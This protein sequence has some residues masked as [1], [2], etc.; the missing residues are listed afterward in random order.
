M[1]EDTL[2][3]SEIDLN[4]DGKQ[5]GYL[6]VPHSVHRSAY[7]WLPVPIVSIKNGH[8]PT[9]L[10]MGGNHGDEYEGQ[11]ALSNLSRSL[12]AKDIK[13]QLIILPAANT[14][15]AQAGLRT[16]PIDEGNLNR[17]F[18]GIANG[19]PTQMIAHYIESVLL[20]HADY[21][22]DIHSGGSS[23]LYQPTL[24]A[25][26]ATNQTLRTKQMALI[27]SLGFPKALIYPEQ[28]DGTYSS[29]AAGRQGVIA[30]T[31][32]IA[33]AGSVDAPALSFLETVLSR[34]LYHIDITPQLTAPA[35]KAA[36]ALL[37]S[38]SEEYC[39]YARDDGVFEP[40]ADIGHEISKDQ[41]VGRIHKPTQPWQPPLDITSPVQAQVI[42]KRVP[43]RVQCGDCLY[44]LAV[45]YK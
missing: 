6:R 30:L 7:G 40:L 17:S 9:A 32:E 4:Q 20:A 34:Y 5:Q 28:L 3:F 43:A 45:A 44:E 36:T 27:K 33:G 37:H 13:G 23:L 42:C 31:A 39:I 24:L 26:Q 21:L 19:P 22:F 18:L 14:P 12:E 11:V 8:G 1:S 10:L 2:I 41:L 15:A 16:S 25:P 35:P 29:S 38:P